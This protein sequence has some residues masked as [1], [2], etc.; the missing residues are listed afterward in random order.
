MYVGGLGAAAGATASLVG[1]VQTIAPTHPRRAPLKNDELGSRAASGAVR[2]L[3]DGPAGAGPGVP[4]HAARRR[5]SVVV[6]QLAVIDLLA[7]IGAVATAYL[8]GF[9]VGDGAPGWVDAV[10]ALALPLVWVGAAAVNG[11]YDRRFV[12]IGSA[13]F[14]RLA[15]A[16]SHLTVVTVFASYAAGLDLARGFLVLALPLGLV[17]SL[18]GRSVARMWMHRRRRAGRS[19]S[20]VL[21]VGR[22]ESVE[23]LASAMRQDLAAGLQVVGACLPASEAR[24]PGVHRRLA[25]IGV[26]VLGDLATVR[27]AVDGCAARSVAVVSADVGTEALRAISWQLEDTGADL[28]VSSGLAE[29]AGRRVHV[30]SVAGLSLLHVD[31]PHFAGARRLAKTVFDRAVAATALLIL[32]PLLLV[33]G[34]LVRC[35]SRGPAFYLQERVGLRGRPFRMVKFRSMQVGAHSQVADLAAHNVADG[36]L[37]KIKDDPRVTRVGKWLRRFSVDEL[38]QLFN[39]LTGSM[40]LVGPRPPLPREVALYPDDVRRR[41]LVKPGLTGLWQVS[42][43]SN[44]SWEEG[45]RLDLHYVENWSFALDVVV[46]LKTARVVVKATGAY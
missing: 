45:I 30:Q 46:L 15:R 22:V 26:S 3:R 33:I 38:P 8:S 9:G 37:F 24:D 41:L 16:F 35:T 1:D 2:D 27:P 28:I 40:S 36:L 42:G 21:A 44:L 17:L 20:P 25:E 39:I 31:A 6:A 7:A 12:G 10:A 29:V 34:L 14:G 19:V 43:R 23:A 32:S 11:A 13:E 4:W 5:R 18:A